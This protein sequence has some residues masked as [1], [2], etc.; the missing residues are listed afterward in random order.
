MMNVVAVPFAAPRVIRNGQ[1]VPA[2]ARVVPPAVSV[3]FDASN[4]NLMVS[5]SSGEGMVGLV[6]TGVSNSSSTDDT[7]LRA[8]LPSGEVCSVAP[9][10]VYDFA[11]SDAI[12]LSGEDNLVPRNDVLPVPS[13]GDVT[14]PLVEADSQ[15]D[16]IE[17]FY[18]NF[19]NAQI[20]L[21]IG[22]ADPA[23]IEANFP[24]ARSSALALLD[25]AALDLTLDVPALIETVPASAAT[26]QGTETL[27]FIPADLPGEATFELESAVASAGSVTEPPP[28]VVAAGTTASS[29]PGSLNPGS[30]A[31]DAPVDLD[32]GQGRVEAFRIRTVITAFFAAGENE[33]FAIEPLELVRQKITV[34]VATKTKEEQLADNAAR[35]IALTLAIDSE[36]NACIL[37]TAATNASLLTGCAVLGFFNPILG[38]LCAIEVG[39][40]TAAMVVQCNLAKAEAEAEVALWKLLADIEACAL[41]TEA[42]RQLEIAA[43]LALLDAL[44]PC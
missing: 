32:A 22:G 30:T 39:V 44:I 1:A 36:H 26:F 23:D 18:L 2:V 41:W 16:S 14:T 27:D 12:G 19:I 8:S 4:S 33:L 31:L 29:S 42:K 13:A 43:A 25:V 11:L 24:G 35:E 34:I 3:D 38:T 5:P 6:L 40:I 28:W 7:L 9:V 21:L 15:F 10:T 37:R 17:I 20:N